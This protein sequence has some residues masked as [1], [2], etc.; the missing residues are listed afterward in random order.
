[1]PALR[2]SRG[3]PEEQ[4]CPYRPAELVG[5]HGDSIRPTPKKPRMA[6]TDLPVPAHQDIE[7]ATPQMQKPK[8]AT[9]RER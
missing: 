2:R 4:L 6:E 3:R 1:M 5:A 9:Q 8:P 7:E